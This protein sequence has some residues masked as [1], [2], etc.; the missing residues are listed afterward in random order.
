MLPLFGSKLEGENA[1]DCLT[2]PARCYFFLFAFF[3]SVL[4]YKLPALTTAL[5]MLQKDFLFQVGFCSTALIVV[6]IQK[7][8]AT[9]T[10]LFFTHVLFVTK[11]L[12]FVYEMFC[13][14]TLYP[15]P[16][17]KMQVS[18]F[19]KCWG[20]VVRVPGDETYTEVDFYFYF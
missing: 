9:A 2:Q 19:T 13:T 15:Q 12:A 16:T 17:F 7:E 5:S 10:M 20:S 1:A 18:H 14:G 8:R 11:R 6:L 4:F 3:S